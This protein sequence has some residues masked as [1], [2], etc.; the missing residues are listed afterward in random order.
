MKKTKKIRKE[1]ASDALP[2]NI[3]GIIDRAVSNALERLDIDALIREAI[4]EMDIAS[5][6]RKTL[7]EAV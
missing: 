1:D 6:V 7:A 4:G 5:I 2:E 3:E